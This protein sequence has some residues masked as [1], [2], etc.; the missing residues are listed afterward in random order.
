[1]FSKDSVAVLQFLCKQYPQ[2]KINAP[3]MALRELIPMI[4]EKGRI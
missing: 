2:T 4:N 1:M 3:N